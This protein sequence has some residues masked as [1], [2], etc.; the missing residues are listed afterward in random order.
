MQVETRHDAGVMRSRS[1]SL[2]RTIR[3]VDPWSLLKFSLLFYGA[4]VVVFLLAGLM[5]YM[6]ASGVGVVD[7]LE[8]FIRDIGWPDF[9]IRASQVFRILFLLGLAN[10]IAWSAI[11]LFLAFLYNLVSDVVGGI[12]V[13]FSER[14]L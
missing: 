7:K 5:L 12:E 1:R 6:V 9:R 8:N 4:V 2:R 13:T 3:H 10:V 14:E 11:N